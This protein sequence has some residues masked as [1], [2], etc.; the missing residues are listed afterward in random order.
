MKTPLLNMS[1]AIKSFFVFITI[2]VSM[3][4]Y[5]FA[6]IPGCTNQYACNFNPA[7]NQDNGSCNFS[8]A[9]WYLPN[10]IAAFNTPAIFS[11]VPIANYTLTPY[12][13]CVESI[14][15]NDVY[16]ANVDWD[17]ICQNALLNTLGCTNI[18]ACNYDPDAICD[19]GTCNFSAAL[20]YLPNNILALNT[21]AILSCNPVNNYTLYPYQSCLQSIINNDPFCIEVDWDFLCQNALNA[22]VGCTNPTACNYNENA[23]CDDASCDFSNATWYLPNNINAI[24]SPAIFTCNPPGN[25]SAAQYPSCIEQ[26]V[27]DDPYCMIT[28]WDNLC[29][30]A[31]NALIGCTDP[32][33]CNYDADHLCDDGSCSIGA[34][35]NPLA[36]NFDPSAICD[37]GSCIIPPVNDNCAN[38]IPLIQGFQYY[39]NSNTC[40]DSP[41]SCVLLDQY[42]AQASDDIWFS[43][44]ATGGETSITCSVLGSPT[45]AIPI[46]YS[47]CGG[48][49]LLCPTLTFSEFCFCATSSV[50]EI[51]CGFLTQGETYLVQIGGDAY[52]AQGLMPAPRTGEIQI[53]F[54]QNGAP[55]SVG[56]YDPGACNYNPNAICG[57]T[58]TLCIFPGCTDPAACNFDPNAGCD[59]GSCKSLDCFGSCGGIGVL[60]NCNNCVEGV[61]EEKVFYYRDL[62]YEF[63]VPE[64]V[65]N[66]SANLYGASGGLIEFLALEINGGTGGFASGLIQ[67]NPGDILYINTGGTGSGITGGFNGGGNG[68]LS[69]FP[70]SQGAGA[71]GGGATDIRTSPF[72]LNSRLLVAAGGGGASS[73][74]AGSV[75]TYDLIV[76]G[77][78]G[79]NIGQNVHTAFGGFA[80]GGTQ[81]EG[82][83]PGGAFGQGADAVSPI[84]SGGGGGGWYGG[85]TDN[86]IR[87]SGAGGSGYAAPSVI[88]AF[89]SQNTYTGNGYVVLTIYKISECI[90][91]CTDENASNYNIQA[92]FYDGSCEYL[93]CDD[94]NAQNFNPFVAIN[95]GTCIYPGCTYLDAQNFDPQANYDNGSCIFPPTVNNC[96]ADI[97]GDGLINTNDL[98]ALLSQFGTVCP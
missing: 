50:L 57:N 40:D 96:A 47:F 5:T 11:C 33:A 53:T 36:C 9:Q 90:P 93:G 18:Y 82:G 27:N 51:P 87:T 32:I 13:E 52:F 23:D 22:I 7:A 61:I 56:C 80:T 2:A 20:W 88:D 43:F 15:T 45:A 16:C 54:S 3:S 98:L 74:T 38:A 19:D 41:G 35:T 71:G 78:G 63:T 24:N 12:Q 65:F 73:K 68:F 86:S 75:Q 44:E 34:C 91:G 92:S 31:Y 17:N 58:T 81:F 29:L 66:I 28:D 37:N 95:N 79:G 46:L 25:Y 42:I 72:D 48:E 21:P 97:T 84:A 59:D 64:N 8:S 67:V 6:Q 85:G 4:T 1:F 10:N 70:N 14:V 94:P 26:V 69:N 83:S 77:D 30:I 55:A 62:T 49:K 89:I 76:G 60:D 39:N